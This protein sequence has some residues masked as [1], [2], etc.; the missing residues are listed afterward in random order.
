VV[1]KGKARKAREGGARVGTEQGVAADRKREIKR[2][3]QQR[4]MIDASVAGR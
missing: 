2:V 4:W 1:R 3:W